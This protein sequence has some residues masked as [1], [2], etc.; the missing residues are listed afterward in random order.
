MT[1]I[2][3]KSIN[4]QFSTFKTQGL[5]RSNSERFLNGSFPRNGSKEQTSEIVPTQI[6][7]SA[8]FPKCRIS[9]NVKLSFITWFCKV[10]IMITYGKF[11]KFSLRCFHDYF[12]TV[13]VLVLGQLPY[14]YHT[15]F[16][17]GRL[18]VFAFS[19]CWN[20]PAAGLATL[21]FNSS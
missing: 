3:T 9:S 15:N 18:V 13:N 7:Q 6:S 21:E 14:W 4:H 10:I 19:Q 11:L 20:T 12:L 8:C 5:S 17:V 2:I 16:K 1:I